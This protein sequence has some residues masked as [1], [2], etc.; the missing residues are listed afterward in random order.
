MG[1]HEGHFSKFATLLRR[2][3]RKFVNLIKRIQVDEAQNVYTAGIP[4]HNQPA[5]RPAYGNFDTIRLLFPKTT[6]VTAFSA[7]F[8]QHIL[9]VVKKKLA[10]SP[11]H[12]II[13]C[14]SNRPNIMYATHKVV[15]ALSEFRNLSFLLP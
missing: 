12:F 2:Q 5:F 9:Q 4:K 6:T 3:D 10:I 11:T 14:T 7:T 15:G 8:P 13:R 1:K